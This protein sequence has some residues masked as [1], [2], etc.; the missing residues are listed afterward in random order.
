[1]INGGS[2]SPTYQLTDSILDTKAIQ[3]RLGEA[4]PHLR[5]VDLRCILHT[6]IQGDDVFDEDVDGV[7]MLLILFVN[8]EGLFIQA[9]FCGNLRDFTHVVVL[10]LVDIADDLAFVSA[11]GS[12]HQQVLQVLVVAK[13]R[14]LQDDFL[15][16]LN[17]LDRQVSRQERLDCDGNVIRIRRLGDGCRDDLRPKVRL[18]CLVHAALALTWS[19]SARRCRFSDVRTWAHNSS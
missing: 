14:R 2:G 9:V 7:G 12:Q 11:D 1:M 13:R 3:L 4:R 16:Q 5:L 18:I 17:E 8:E 15:E 10:E 19:I 6:T